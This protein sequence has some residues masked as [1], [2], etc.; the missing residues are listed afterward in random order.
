MLK[1][2][3]K[4]TFAVLKRRKFFSFISLFGISFTLVVLIV[5]T[6]FIEHIFSSGYPEANQDRTLYIDRFVE[7]DTKHQGMSSG[8]ISYNFIKKYVGRIADAQ[9]IGFTSEINSINTYIN[10]QKIKLDYK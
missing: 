1:N 7:M 2:Y 6:A 4:I 8:P 9:K 5:I 3:L 10:H